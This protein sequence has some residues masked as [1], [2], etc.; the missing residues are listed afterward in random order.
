MRITE[1][2]EKVLV[3]NHRKYKNRRENLNWIPNGKTFS[4]WKTNDKSTKED[5]SDTDSD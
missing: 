2:K 4:I 1:S 5:A 3:E